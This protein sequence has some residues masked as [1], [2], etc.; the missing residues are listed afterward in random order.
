MSILFKTLTFFLTIMVFAVNPSTAADSLVV[1][2]TNPTTS[3]SISLSIIARGWNCCTN[4]LHDSTSVNLLNDSTITLSFTASLQAPCPCPS[5]PVAAVLN[6]KRGPLPK[7]NYSVY[8]EYQSCT[9]MICPQEAAIVI[10]ALIGKFTVSQPT[11]TIF[12]QK[13]VRLE[14][15]G[16]SPQQNGQVYDIR[17]G[18]VSSNLIGT[19]KRTSGVYFFKPDDHAAVRMKIWY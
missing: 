13:S 11:T 4:F 12:H 10:Q 2:P 15:I 3:D 9:G 8:E 5:N 1:N 19:S 14:D 17:G 16:K 18:V 7:G 6:Y